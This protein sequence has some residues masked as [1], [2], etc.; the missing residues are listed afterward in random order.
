MTHG[1]EEIFRDI[2]YAQCWEDPEID[3]EAFRIE[4]D[5]TVFSITSGGCNTL[6][7]LID[8]P[9]IVYA[10]D[11]NPRQNYLLDLKMGAFAAL[12]YGEMLELLGIRPSRRRR[13]LYARVR[14]GL[15]DASRK[16]WDEHQ[17]KVDQGL[18]HVG[19]Y[20]AYMRL[21]RHCL[22]RLKGKRLIR[23]LFATADPDER[24]RLYRQRW[25]T[26]SWRLF[27]RVFLSRA[28][29]SSL[30]T[31]EFFTY[32]EGSF[33][34]G[35]HFAQL[36]ERA[37]TRMPLRENYFASYILLGRYFDEDH[38]PP[39][40]MQE[41][42]T[43]IRSRL[44]RVHVMTGTCDEFFTRMP[45]SS[46]QKFNFTNIFEWMPE[47]AFEG[48]LREVWRVASPDAVMTYRNLLVFRERPAVLHTMI[49][50]DRALAESLHARDRS[51][52]YRNY[53]VE[54]INKRKTRWSTR[55]K[56]SMTAAG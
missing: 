12:P 46:I 20:E 17:V 10:L 55:S 41:N 23:E 32:V 52:I 51:F 26:P 9:R 35:K 22:E 43:L 45:D 56:Q 47:E 5:D 6:S 29:M 39:Y 48:I 15:G 11:L 30:F 2:I 34:F 14:D 31:S 3:R 44:A 18:I 25:D 1:S 50:P 13:E 16:Y 19:R 27:T 28:V 38:L 42:F 40:L 24:L 49:Q 53:V 4:P 37:L 33:S 21:L 8:N 7:F 54:R 36:V